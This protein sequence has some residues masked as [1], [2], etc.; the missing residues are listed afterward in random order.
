MANT[1]KTTAK[2]TVKKTAK[3]TVKK[4]TAKK[5]APAKK[6]PQVIIVMRPINEVIESVKNS[7]GSMFSKQDVLSLLETVQVEQPK[8]PE[9]KPARKFNYD[10]IKEKLID[11][12]RDGNLSV[13]IDSDEV[14]DKDD[15]DLSIGFDN[16]IE[17]DRVGV[18]DSYL[19]SQCED[20]VCD[21]VE[22]F[23]DEIDEEEEN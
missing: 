10:E 7:V 8:A 22:K 16:K 13:D 6:E 3:K 18:D 21:A 4:V 1:K 17:I 19:S 5:K 15:I 2:K 9:K 12:L 20:A 14:I 11:Y 23:F